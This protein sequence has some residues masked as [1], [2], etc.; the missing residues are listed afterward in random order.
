[1]EE[2]KEHWGITLLFFIPRLI[3]RIFGAFDMSDGGLSL[4]KILAA[5]ATLEAAYV[6]DKMLE[7]NNVITFTFIWLGY[8]GILIGI[9]SFGDIA[10]ALGGLKQTP[11]GTNKQPVQGENTPV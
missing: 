10:G 6:T 4:K 9:Y 5:F 8:A 3:G 7:P 11:S 1:M 2:K